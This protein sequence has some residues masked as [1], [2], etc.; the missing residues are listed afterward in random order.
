MG[1]E[2]TFTLEC[3]NFNGAVTGAG[4]VVSDSSTGLS[5][6]VWIDADT[7]TWQ[8]GVATMSLTVTLK[9]MMDTKKASN[10]ESSIES[11]SSSSGSSNTTTVTSTYGSKSNPPFAT[12]NKYWNVVKANIS[13]WNE[14]YGYYMANGG[15]GQGWKIVDKNNKEVQL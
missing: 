7:H 10:T 4:A 6:V 13:T 14:A 11:G 8:N 15:T 5:G 12:L 2:K 9:Q 1:V 3:V